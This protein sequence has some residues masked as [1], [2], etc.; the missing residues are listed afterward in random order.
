MTDEEIVELF[1]SRSE[2]AI[3]ALASKH[4]NAVGKLAVNIL[5]DMSDAEECINDTW[6]GVWNS[7]PPNRPEQLRTYVCRVARNLAL[8]K[9]HSERAQKRNSRYDVALEELGDCVASRD[10]VESE[11]AAR[12]LAA[13]INLFLAALNYEDRFIFVRRYWYADSLDEVARMTN[14]SYNNVSQRLHRVRAKLK[15]FLDEEV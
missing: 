3:S 8:K 5:G 12:Q 15:R 6:L 7:I 1:Y 14:L 13:S 2:Q 11:Y 10:T 4:G 9:Y